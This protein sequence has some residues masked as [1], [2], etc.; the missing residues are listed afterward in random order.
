MEPWPLSHG[1]H[2][3]K[4]VIDGGL[5]ILQWS[6]SLSAM[7]TGP[8]QKT[9]HRLAIPFNGAMTFQPWI[10]GRHLG[11]LGSAGVPSMEP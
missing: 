1:Y 8:I 7:D 4:R 11:G 2:P 3:L 6:H 5:N 9:Q 10:P